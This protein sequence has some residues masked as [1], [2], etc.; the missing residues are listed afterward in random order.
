MK[1]GMLTLFRTAGF[2]YPSVF[3]LGFFS[4]SCTSVYKDAP[5]AFGDAQEELSRAETIGTERHF[6]NSVALAGEKFENASELFEESL[7]EK[8]DELKV[9][10]LNEATSLA[11]ESYSISR[12]ANSMATNIPVWDSDIN[13][14]ASEVQSSG[15][16]VGLRQRVADLEGSNEQ[17]KQQVKVVEGLQKN[18]E[19]GL[20]RVKDF[21]F[22]G[23]VAFFGSSSSAVEPNYLGRIEEIA[24]SLRQS[25]ALMARVSAYTDNTGS[26]AHNE[27]VKMARAESVKSILVSRGVPESQIEINTNTENSPQ[28]T[29][30]EG[31]L[32]LQR[33]VDIEVLSRAE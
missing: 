27:P 29:L 15:D 23:S 30:H 8:N 13:F 24:D 32:Q 9:S 5:L 28:H 21:R 10:K 16:V 19:N 11:E 4:V 2:V 20:A 1:A 25:P 3:A 18:A 12:N 17:L 7:S 33:R 6:P 31:K 26:T 22:Q 14:A